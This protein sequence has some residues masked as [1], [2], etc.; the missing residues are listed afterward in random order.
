MRLFVI[1]YIIKRTICDDKAYRNSYVIIN[2]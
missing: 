1:F 2:E